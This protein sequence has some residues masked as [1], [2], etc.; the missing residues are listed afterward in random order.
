MCLTGIG[1]WYEWENIPIVLCGKEVD[2]KDR[3]VKAKSTVLPRK[4][5]QYYDIAATSNY[6]LARPF[7][8]ESEACRLLPCQHSLGSTA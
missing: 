2:V 5:L 7:L 6:S 3:K 1:I 4:N 8:L